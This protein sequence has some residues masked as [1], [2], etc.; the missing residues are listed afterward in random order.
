MSIGESESGGTWHEYRGAVDLAVW[1]AIR[2][3]GKAVNGPAVA[4]ST[5][6]WKPETRR[7]PAV[8]SRCFYGTGSNCYLGGLSRSGSAPRGSRTV[9]TAAVV[10]RVFC[11]NTKVLSSNPNHLLQKEHHT[12]R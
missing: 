3:P 6:Y 1:L 4:Q 10:S 12:V 7:R 2:S 8:K 9:S 5:S 11:I